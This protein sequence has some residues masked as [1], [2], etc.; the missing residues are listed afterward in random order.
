[1]RFPK[2]HNI[3]VDLGVERDRDSSFCESLDSFEL[4]DALGDTVS[5]LRG[6]CGVSDARERGEKVRPGSG[7]YPKLRLGR[8][9]DLKHY[10]ARVE[11]LLPKQLS[12]TT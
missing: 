1:M 5:V 12:T 2:V 9:A 7:L 6:G 11:W 4:E 8:R 3:V 10:Y